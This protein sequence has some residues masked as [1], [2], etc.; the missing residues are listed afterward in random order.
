MC[1]KCD[2]KVVCGRFQSTGGKVKKCEHYSDRLQPVNAADQEKEATDLME[3]KLMEIIYTAECAGP[4]REDFGC[5]DRR[6]NGC[7]QVKKLDICALRR[8]AE[9]LIAAGVRLEER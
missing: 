1:E 9:A 7:A 4:L 5:W 6:W 3:D 2:H 8:I